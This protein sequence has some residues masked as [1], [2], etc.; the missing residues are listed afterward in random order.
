MAIFLGIFRAIGIGLY[1]RDFHTP[2]L[3][4]MCHRALYPL[5]IVHCDISQCQNQ[6]KFLPILKVLALIYFIS[7]FECSIS[8]FISEI[9]I[10]QVWHKS[11]LRDC[12]I[13]Q[14]KIKIKIFG[15]TNVFFGKFSRGEGSKAIRVSHR[16]CSCSIFIRVLLP[17]SKSNREEYQLEKTIE[18][19]FV[20]NFD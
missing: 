14:I 10:F 20:L 16:N 1:V 4:P 19:D 9:D 18:S 8:T 17:K 15:E 11:S 13:Q 6:L 3:C 2:T 12:S 5:P 7:W